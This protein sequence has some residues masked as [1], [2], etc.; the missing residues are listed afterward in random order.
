MRFRHDEWVDLA[1]VEE[2]REDLD[3]FCAEVLASIPRKD[4]RAWGNC[5]LRGL[6]LDGRRKSIQ[7]MAERRPDGDM[8]ALQQFVTSSPWEHTPVRRRIATQLTQAIN[9][10]AW[11][12]DDTSFPKAGKHS[13]GAVRQWCGALGKKSL[14]QVGVSLHSVTDAASVPLDWRL[15]L[16]KEWADPADPRRDRAGYPPR[17]GASGEVAFGPGHDRC[18]PG[19]GASGPGRRGRRRIRAEPPLS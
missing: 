11:V 17:S 7:P 10:D 12:I 16:P 14:C 8:Q 2:L 3:A 13:V 19:V 18:G 15:F 1:A 5:Y 4:S 9:P 6:M